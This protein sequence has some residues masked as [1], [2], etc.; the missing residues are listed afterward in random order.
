MPRLKVLVL[1][2]SSFALAH[3][4][5]H[6]DVRPGPNGINSVIIPAERSDGA[7][8]EARSQSE[9]YCEQFKKKPIVLKE[10]SQYKGPHDEKTYN[11]GKSAAKA[12]KVVGTMAAFGGSSTVRNAGA[13]VGLAG[14]GGDAYL[15]EGYSYTLRFRCVKGWDR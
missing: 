2:L 13:G 14:A 7:Y 10:G 3:C 5:H 11:K 6:R 1:L 8:R 15:G 12:A 4:A 9:H